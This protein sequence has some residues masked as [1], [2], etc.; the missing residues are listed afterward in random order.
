MTGSLDFGKLMEVSDDPKPPV[1]LC[2]VIAVATLLGCGV[3]VWV[4]SGSGSDTTA[5]AAVS[6]VS[7]DLQQV[8]E[9][10][11]IYS[12]PP[13]GEDPS[14]YPRHPSGAS[15]SRNPAKNN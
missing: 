11:Q 5:A 1:L 9:L 14:K 6:K 7:R 8:I 3:F 10:K 12:K 15:S 2:S 13:E 4:R